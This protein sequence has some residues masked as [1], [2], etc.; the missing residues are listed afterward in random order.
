MVKYI[1]YS[2]GGPGLIREED[3]AYRLKAR[4]YRAFPA[5]TWQ[6]TFSDTLVPEGISVP[7]PGFQGHCMHMVH[8]HA[9]KTPMHIIS[10]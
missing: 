6:L 8:I 3:T 5:P 10:K 2:G 1:V 9:I 7:S 4:S